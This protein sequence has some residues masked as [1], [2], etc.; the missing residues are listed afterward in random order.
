[1]STPPPG[2]RARSGEARA[3]G[4]RQHY[5]D[6]GG[7]GPALLIVPG[8]TM[9][10]ACVEFLA[11]PLSERHRVISV[12]PRG[13]GLSEQP[14]SGYALTDYAG[15][16]AALIDALGLDRPIAL[17]H[18][19]GARIVAALA[20]YHPD[21]AG[22]VILADPPLT[23]PGRD[24]YP[25][26]IDPYVDSLRKAKRGAT[27]DDMRPAF[28]TWSDEHL[29]LRALW[30]G[31]CSEAAVV[32]TYERFHSEDLHALLPQIRLP[33]L[34]VYGAD[35]PVVPASELPEV[36]ALMPGA[37]FEAIARAGHMIPWDNLDD[38]VAVILQFTGEQCPPRA[39][40]QPPRP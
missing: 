33:A 15:D 36:R 30:L 40:P 29:A 12:D 18:S 32:E 16:L 11:L 10:A 20:A 7:D 14:S 25:V 13:R 37:R 26:P 27:A 8:I 3:N 34:F 4:I 23:G 24:P 22:A 2:A 28:P 9:P 17:G 1:V 31:R 19:M 6:Y 39:T 21:A 35:S 38:F 5:L